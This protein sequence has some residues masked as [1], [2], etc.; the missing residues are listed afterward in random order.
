MDPVAKRCIGIVV[1]FP[2]LIYLWFF[3]CITFPNQGEL[4]ERP[5][6]T[7]P[8]T[9][10]EEVTRSGWQRR[11]FLLVISCYEAGFQNRSRQLGRG[12]QLL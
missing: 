9:S 8:V 4:A 5:P 6:P 11:G 12:P 1:F 7:S 2:V 10:D 3:V